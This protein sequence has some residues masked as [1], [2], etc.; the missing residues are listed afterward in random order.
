VDVMP[1]DNG[2]TETVVMADEGTGW[3]T[4]AAKVAMID[5]TGLMADAETSG[6]LADNENPVALLSESLERARVDSSVSAVILRINSPGGTVT[7]SDVMYRDVVRFRDETGKPVV[8][9]MGE[10]AASGG[11]YLACAGDRVIAHPTSITGSIG[12]IIQ[13]INV[14]EGMKRI[15]VRAE[16]ITSGPNKRMGSPL[17]PM[18]EEHREL[19]Q[20][21]VDEFYAGFRAVVVEARSGLSPG[22]LDW[23]TD[24]RVVTGN[25]AAEVGLVDA[26]GDLHDAFASAKE[27]ASLPRAR[28]V[29][30]HRATQRV[31]SPYART[32]APPAAAQLN[33]L[34]LNLDGGPLRE[35]TG[36]Y[37]LWDPSVW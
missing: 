11:Y 14:A 13:T 5:V 32:P 28:L 19:L 22:D 30:Y 10:V 27:L 31:G 6:L 24:G 21:I 26:T 29:K 33:V 7:A 23:V 15:G 8:V 35:G 18:P 9:L 17:E 2:L 37:Y 1:V 36:F 4:S 3:G 20:G 16:S 25:R 34:Q 12:V